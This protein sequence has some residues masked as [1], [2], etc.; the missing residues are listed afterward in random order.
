ME[1]DA[2]AKAVQEVFDGL[3][4]CEEILSKNRYL[5][6]GQLTYNDIRLFP[7]LARFDE[8]YVVHF[9]VSNL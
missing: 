8:V 5:N 4:K 9:K 1:L 6:G 3:D 2:D 7:T